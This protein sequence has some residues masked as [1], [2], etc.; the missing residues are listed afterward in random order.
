MVLAYQLSNDPALHTI[1]HLALGIASHLGFT[2]VLQY[3]LS[4]AETLGRHRRKAPTA[5]WRREL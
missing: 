5:S 1:S 2:S 4:V 3:A